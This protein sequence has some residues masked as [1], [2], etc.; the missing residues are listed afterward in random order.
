MRYNFLFCWHRYALD[1]ELVLE[2]FVFNWLA[3]EALAGDTDI[4]T[5]CDKC[6][7]EVEHCGN[8]IRHRSSSKDAARK[9]FQAAH[10]KTTNQEFDSKI[11]GRARNRVFHGR[12]YPRPSY[13]KE[14][15]DV[16]RNVH[17]AVDLQIERVLLD[18]ERYRPHVGYEM[19]F[20]HFLFIEWNTSD[21]ARAFAHDYPITFME[22]M[23]AEE[24]PGASYREAQMAG[25]LI[26]DYERDNP[27][28]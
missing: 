10:P 5:R 15:N 11:W 16:S 8:V 26:L 22:R 23:A 18:G 13:L 28:W 2:Q 14:L 12:Q 9:I 3:F 6:G 20:R 1:R 7:A 4:S 24:Q 27:G 19:W 21:P 25:I 17:S